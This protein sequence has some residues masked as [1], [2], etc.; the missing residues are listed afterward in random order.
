MDKKT[1]IEALGLISRIKY[2]IPKMFQKEIEKLEQEMQEY[3]EKN[4][5]Y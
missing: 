4:T 3:Y 1:V 5:S 2:I